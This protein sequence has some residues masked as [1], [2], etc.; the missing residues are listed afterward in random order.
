MPDAITLPPEL[1]RYVRSVS[2]KESD[3]QRRLREE[4]EARPDASMLTSPEQAQFLALMARVLGARLCLEVGVYT[5]YTSL[6]LAE[7]LPA[8]GRLIAC[9]VSDDLT[10]IARR[11]WREAGIG[12]KIDLRIAPALETLDLLLRDGYAGRFDLAYIDADKESYPDYYERSLQLLRRGGVIAADNV[13]RGG[14]AYSAEANDHATRVMRAFNERVHADERV[15]MCLLPMR[16][17]LTLACK[18]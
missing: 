12:P 16:D 14:M 11:Y 2:L 3:L 18:K 7:A 10:A 15:W 13:L 1:T 6:C 4:T 9:D 17:G 5:G 8:D